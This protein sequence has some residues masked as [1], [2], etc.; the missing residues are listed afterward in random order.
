MRISDWSSD[1]CSSDLDPYRPLARTAPGQAV[2][3]EVRPV[4]VQVVALDWKWLFIYPDQGIATVNE[5]AIPAH[6]PVRFRLSA[7]SEERRGGKEWVRTGRFRW[8]P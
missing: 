8:L 6:R 5:L 4:E 3:A 7:R 1:V 2:A